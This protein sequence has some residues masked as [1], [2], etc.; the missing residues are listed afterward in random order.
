MMVLKLTFLL[1]VCFELKFH[2]QYNT[3]HIHEGEI[4]VVVMQQ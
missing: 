3:A 2:K 4:T 1:F